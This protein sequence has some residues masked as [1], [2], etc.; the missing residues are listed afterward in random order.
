M[1]TE[2]K[3]VRDIIGPLMLVEGVEGVT[4]NELAQVKLPDGSVR[5]SQVLEV[6]G[7]RALVQIFEG[8]SGL[9]LRTVPLVSIHWKYMS[10][11]PCRLW[12]LAYTVEPTSKLVSSAV[13]PESE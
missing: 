13:L 9:T 2:Y 4:Y 1:I 3:A 6:D 8:T 5:L 10:F 11:M 7:D 12:A